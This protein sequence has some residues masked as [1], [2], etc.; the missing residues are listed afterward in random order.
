M[1]T[2]EQSRMDNPKT[3]ATLG[4]I[5]RQH[6]VQDTGNIGHKT[7]ATLGTRHRQH[8]AQDTGNIGHKTQATLGTKHRQH[9]A[10]DT[11]NIGYKTQNEDKQMEKAQHR[12]TKKM[13]NTNSTKTTQS[14]VKDIQFLFMEAT[15]LELIA[16]S[17]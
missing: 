16:H 4:T 7:Q 11:G 2:I 8:W 6:W 12:K 17:F 10:Q 1:K 15:R 3:Q 9:W 14:L 5:H 13:G